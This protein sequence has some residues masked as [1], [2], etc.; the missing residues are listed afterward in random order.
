MLM[1]NL[2]VYCGKYDSYNN[3]KFLTG[4]I[5]SIENLLNISETS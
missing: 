5:D 3:I 1:Y 4:D 2:D